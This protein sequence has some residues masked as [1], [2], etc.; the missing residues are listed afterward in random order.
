MPIAKTVNERPLL[1]RALHGITT[2]FPSEFKV[3][4]CDVIRD[5]LRAND[6]ARERQ[7]NQ[8]PIGQIRGQLCRRLTA[9]RAMQSAI[10]SPERAAAIGIKIEAIEGDIQRIDIK[11]DSVRRQAACRERAALLENCRAAG[12]AAMSALVTVFNTDEFREHLMD[13][14]SSEIE[15]VM[16]GADTDSF[17]ANRAA[18]LADG[19]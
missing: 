12:A 6:Q 8:S 9:N 11:L 14:L 7:I 5:R 10:R 16:A 13:F 4:T 17:I 19:D 2:V 1:R 18:M 3:V 15:Q